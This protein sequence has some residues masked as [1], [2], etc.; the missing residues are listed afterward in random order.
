MKFHLAAVVL[1]GLALGADS[2]DEA[3]KNELKSL[4]GIWTLKSS[5]V[6]E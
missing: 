2:P 6:D 1:A 3:I 4:E 5:I